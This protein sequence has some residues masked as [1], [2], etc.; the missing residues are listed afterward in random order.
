MDLVDHME[1]ATVK[2]AR[3]S[4][5]RPREKAELSGSSNM[6]STHNKRVLD[7]DAQRSLGVLA[8]SRSNTSER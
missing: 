8:S 5:H 2:L 4:L 1:I 3:L 7:Q 6:V